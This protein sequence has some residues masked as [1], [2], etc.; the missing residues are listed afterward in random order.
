MKEQIAERE[1]ERE[2]I[3]KEEAVAQEKRLKFLNRENINLTRRDWL[4]FLVIGVLG[5]QAML[6]LGLF[7]TYGSL[8]RLANKPAPSL[9]QLSDGRSVTV[10]AIQA[11]ERTPQTITNFV[12]SVFSLMFTWSGF[13]PPASDAQRQNLRPDPGVRISG[14]RRVPTTTFQ[15]AFALSPDFR[16]EFLA[17]VAG[18]IP[19]GVFGGTTQVVLEIQ[20]ISP[21][22]KIADGKWKVQVVASLNVIQQ[23]DALS[24][25]IPFNKEVFLQAVEPPSYPLEP[26][27]IEK[28]V[29]GVRSAGLEIY[30]I[31]DLNLENL[32]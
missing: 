1:L 22:Q 13:L 8:S 27:G 6:V 11:S 25:I 15:A 32:K 2:Q 9:V 12:N 3:L 30:A 16:K 31:R 4:G 17:E 28:A 10:G 21:S 7:L 26:S 14:G 20:Q 23:S 19:K 18:L 24:Q 29:Y 5:L